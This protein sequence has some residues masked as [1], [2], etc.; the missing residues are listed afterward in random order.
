M[1]QLSA[2]N[3]LALL[4][5]DA[6]GKR[7]G[8]MGYGLLR[9]SVAPVVVVVDKEA[10]G[11]DLRDLTGIEEAVGIPIVASLA[12]ALAYHP[13]VLVPAIAPAGGVLPAAWK[14]EIAEALGT[15]LS[16]VN[17]LHTPMAS[18]PVFS[19][20]VRQPNQFIWDIRREPSDLQTGTG[21]AREVSARR[22]LLVGTDMNN[23]KMTTA[24][25]ITKSLVAAGVRAK[26]LATGQIGIAIAGDGVPLDAVRVDYASGAVEQ[27][28]LRYGSD[29]DVLLIEGQG[30]LLHP[31]STATLPLLRGSLPTELIL[32]HRAGQAT[33]SQMPWVPIPPLSE[34][35]RLYETVATAAGALPAA[36][37]V[38]VA[39]NTATLSDTEARAAV[40]QT[41][42]EVGL[43]VTDVVRFGPNPLTEAIYPPANAA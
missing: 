12:E 3:R 27:L 7:A 32:C 8:K 15:G 26:F 33:I 16:L 38:G 37:V 20:L 22:V 43:P 18:D 4:M 9:Y 42:Q 40:E 31:S 6:V 34:V 11:K 28:V 23:G 29:H 2:N 41:Q 10:A 17:G 39:L 35:I 21:R 14:D 25:E 36:R 5:H 24:L 1:P 13:D 19:G 30:S